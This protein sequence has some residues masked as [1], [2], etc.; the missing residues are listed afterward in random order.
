VIDVHE[1]RKATLETAFQPA[2]NAALAHLKKIGKKLQVP[3][4]QCVLVEGH[5]APGVYFLSTGTFRL[6]VSSATDKV[7]VGT[8]NAGDLL[9]L[10]SLYGKRTE[11]LSAYATKDCELVFISRADFLGFL[12]AFPEAHHLV[13]KILSDEAMRADLVVRRLRLTQA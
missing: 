3:C 7:E 1:R 10:A 6:Y 8:A 13:N 5:H 11:P 9:G 4:G 12:H 2:G